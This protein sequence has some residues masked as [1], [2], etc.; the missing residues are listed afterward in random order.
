M[1]SRLDLTFGH[2]LLADERRP[3]ATEDAT[4]GLV[5]RAQAGEAAAFAALL[6]RHKQKVLATALRLLGNR[7]D[8]MDAAQESFLRVHKYLGSYDEREGD[9]GAWVHAIVVNVCRRVARRRLPGVNAAHAEETAPAPSEDLEARV[10][11]GE[12]R[13][14]LDRALAT[15]TERERSAFVLRDLEGLPTEEVARLLGSAPATIRVHVCMARKKLRRFLHEQAGRDE[16]QA[17]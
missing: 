13:R 4:A 8:A 14:R 6:G 9:F 5:A 7:D 1:S 15:L 12:E 3:A 16:E 17:P 10:A 11:A 2:L